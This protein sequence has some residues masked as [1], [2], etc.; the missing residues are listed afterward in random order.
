MASKYRKKQQLPENF[1][2]LLED[3]SREVLRDQP[4]DIVEF[5]Y[6][7]FKAIEEDTLD[8]FN[9]P[10]KGKNIPPPR[11][12]FI[13]EDDEEGAYGEEEGQ[14]ELQ[15]YDEHGQPQKFYDENGN[16]IPFEDVKQFMMQ[17]QQYGEE[18][19]GEEENN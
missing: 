10:R 9:Y 17:Q 7:Y 8:Q 2:P 6:L 14:Q 5:S 4:M 18:Q 3:Y 11:E 13:E 19:Y 16:E 1:Y 12:D 15:L